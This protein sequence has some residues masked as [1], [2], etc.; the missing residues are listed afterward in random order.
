MNSLR[1]LTVNMGLLMCLWVNAAHS[2]P[3]S[4][5]KAESALKKGQPELALQAYEQM[6]QD[7][8]DGAQLQYNIGSL[9]MKKGD[10]ARAIFHLEKAK[11]LAPFDDNINANL[12]VARASRVD[13]DMGAHQQP[14]WWELAARALPWDIGIGIWLGL[15]ALAWLLLILRVAFPAGNNRVSLGWILFIGGLGF[16]FTGILSFRVTLDDKTFAALRAAESNGKSAPAASA[17]TA[18]TAHAG[19][20]GE[21]LE[22]QNGFLRLRLHNGL[23][24]WFEE[25]GLYV[26]PSASKTEPNL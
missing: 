19:A 11:Q 18:F 24:A 26:G 2:Q 23:E 15:L 3:P 16:I 12:E 20:Y 9:A 5:Q 10:L 7:G 8:L 13:A 22:A 6:L 14:G 4:L 25:S 17:E 21:I 1:T